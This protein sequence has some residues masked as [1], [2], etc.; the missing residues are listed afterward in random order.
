MLTAALAY[1]R[2]ALKWHQRAQVYGSVGMLQPISRWHVAIGESRRAL[3]W[4]HVGH[5]SNVNKLAK[6][7]AR[8]I[9]RATHHGRLVICHLSLPIKHHLSI[10]LMTSSSPFF[11]TRRAGLS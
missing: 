8:I 11:E 1:A 5:V 3:R 2:G 7:G 4:R 10:S 6:I 9:S